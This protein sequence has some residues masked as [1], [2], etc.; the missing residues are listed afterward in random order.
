MFNRLFR[1][2]KKRNPITLKIYIF[3]NKELM[4][5][6]FDGKQLVRKYIF[7][8][9]GVWRGWFDNADYTLPFTNRMTKYEN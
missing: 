3:R 7:K 9:F 1:I 2:F 5:Q 8:K 4:L 6:V